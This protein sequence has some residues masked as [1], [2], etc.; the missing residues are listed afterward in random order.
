[1]D[2][3]LACE[4]R[5]AVKSILALFGLGFVNAAHAINSFAMCVSMAIFNFSVVSAWFRKDTREQVTVRI[6][7]CAFCCIL[8]L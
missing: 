6:E 4:S 1:M 8:A 7:G 2:R 3:L 5:W